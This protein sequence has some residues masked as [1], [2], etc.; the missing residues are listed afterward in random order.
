MKALS[1]PPPARRSV[2][3]RPDPVVVSRVAESATASIRMRSASAGKPATA[4]PALL[5]PR[6][7]PIATLQ[8]TLAWSADAPATGSPSWSSARTASRPGA[9]RPGRRRSAS[10]RGSRR[11]RATRGSLNCR[12]CDDRRGD[13]SRPFPRTR[14]RRADASRAAA[15]PSR[16]ASC[17]R[18]CCRTSAPRRT[19]GRR[20]SSSRASA[21]TC[22]ELAVLAR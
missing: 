2:V 17:T 20:G 12:R 16:I 14:S 10:V 9:G 11:Q 22:R 1:G 21:P 7:A 6:A 18:S 19:R 13:A 5:Y 3:A 15:G 4:R 8:P